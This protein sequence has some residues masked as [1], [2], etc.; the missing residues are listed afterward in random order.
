[1]EF[2]TLIVL[3]TTLHVVNAGLL[4][5]APELNSPCG[6]EKGDCP[7]L[8]CIPLAANCT[9]F[10]HCAGTCQVLSSPQQ[11]YTICGGWGF[12]DDCDER[13]ESCIADPRNSDCGPP[14]DGMGIC[15]PLQDYC[16][17]GSGRV[18]SGDKACFKTG[19]MCEEDESSGEVS[20]CG[21][22]CL[23]LRFG[24]DSY[25]KS[26]EVEVFRTDQNGNQ[27]RKGED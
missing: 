9:D 25:E 11:I 12:F 18:C 17:S 6:A 13:I 23:P 3:L 5:D 27:E 26:K 14:C 15:A 20:L 22:M 19:F 7:S 8:T 1:M 10:D 24:S 16:G 4:P 21:G 2:L